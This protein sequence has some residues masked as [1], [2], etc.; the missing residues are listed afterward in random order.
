MKTQART[1]DIK[2]IPIGNSRGVRIPSELLK[3]YGFS[4]SLLLEE[5][6]QGLLLKKKES[7]K[8]SWEDTYKD[9]AREKEDWSEFDGTLLDGLSDEEFDNQS[10]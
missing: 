1:R 9:M 3:K 5:T 10:L 2:L 4:Q 6:E 7:D 8:L